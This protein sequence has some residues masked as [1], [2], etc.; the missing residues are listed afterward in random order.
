MVASHFPTDDNE[1]MT[2]EER[3]AA[4]AAAYE[5]LDAER[6]IELFCTIV[7]MLDESGNLTVTPELAPYVAIARALIAKTAMKAGEHAH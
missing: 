5:R 7:A 3:I 6:R 4:I 2:R 1:L